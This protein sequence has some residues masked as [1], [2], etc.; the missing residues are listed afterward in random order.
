MSLRHGGGRG[1]ATGWRCRRRRRRSQALSIEGRKC[2]AP[3]GGSI[4]TLES[5]A[6][7][8]DR[9]GGLLT[10][11]GI[12]PDGK[13]GGVGTAARAGDPAPVGALNLDA[14]DAPAGIQADGIVACVA[15]HEKRVAR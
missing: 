9:S 6:G 14:A 12:H 11:V 2:F 3:V 15:E 10:L 4:G 1:F 8:L 5:E 13:A 7:K